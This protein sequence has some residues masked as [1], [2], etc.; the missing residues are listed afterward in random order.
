[1][2]YLD[3]TRTDELTCPVLVHFRN[4]TCVPVGR[5][6]LES[7]DRA[8]WSDG[9]RRVDITPVRYL[10]VSNGPLT[11]RYLLGENGRCDYQVRTYVYGD[12][13]ETRAVQVSIDEDHVAA[14]PAIP[15]LI[16]VDLPAVTA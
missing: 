3:T 5:V 14:Q 1:M 9:G 11:R 6:Y 12:P 15:T 16:R 13:C 4:A 10:K 8:E 2:S 7:D